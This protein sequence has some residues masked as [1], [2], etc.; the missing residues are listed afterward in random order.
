MEHFALERHLWRTERI[1]GRKD[2]LGGEHTALEARAFRTASKKTIQLNNL[3]HFDRCMFWGAYLRNE[4]LPLEE[5]LLG[6]GT[7]YDSLRWILC[8]L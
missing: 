7:S 8:E 5:I 6:D 3:T 1:V 4:C 2:K